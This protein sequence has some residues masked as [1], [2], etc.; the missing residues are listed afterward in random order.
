MVQQGE[1]RA[2]L[3]EETALVVYTACESLF[4]QAPLAPAPL[5]TAAAP[6]PPPVAP[7]P[8]PSFRPIEPPRAPDHA[9]RHEPRKSAQT[10]WALEGAMLVSARAYTR[11]A[12][13]VT[14]FGLGARAQVGNARTIPGV[15]LLGQFSFPFSA[16]AQSV[17]LSTSVWSARVEPS[18]ELIRS[19]LLRLDVGGGGGVDVFVVAPVSS[20]PGAELNGHQKD[21]S[22]VISALLSGSLA[23]SATSRLVV[24]GMLDYDLQP[25]RYLVEQGAQTVVIL[26]PWR[27]RPALSL[28]FVFDLAGSGQHP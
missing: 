8:P 26:E 21:V 25:R 15:W 14:G 5:P 16:S 6:E 20:V 9:P 27:V 3:L 23:T 7:A 13:T 28:G 12:S 17:E 10:P 11:D 1:S 24:A 19:G 2:V 22:P 4:E 18:L